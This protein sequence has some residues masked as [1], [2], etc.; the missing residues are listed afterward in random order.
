MISGSL[1]APFGSCGTAAPVHPSAGAPHLADG[2]GAK[3][4]RRWRVAL[5][6][7]PESGKAAT[8]P[9]SPATT[10]QRSSQPESR[11]AGDPLGRHRRQQLDPGPGGRSDDPFPARGRHASPARLTGPPHFYFPSTFP[12][13]EMDPIL[14]TIC[15][16]LCVYQVREFL[17]PSG[18]G[19][20]SVG[21][22]SAS[23][24]RSG[25]VTPDSELADEEVDRL[26]QP[27]EALGDGERALVHAMCNVMKPSK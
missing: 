2:R 14:M 1:R 6:T 11:R 13:L 23:R 4:L 3:Q 19:A 17:E 5:T 12:T 25:L 27:N 10:L 7:A 22:R 26:G 20:A 16:N 18:L 15:P 9:S 21:L 24:Q 8:G